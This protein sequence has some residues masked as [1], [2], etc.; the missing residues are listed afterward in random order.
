MVNTRGGLDLEIDVGDRNTPILTSK[1]KVR[2]QRETQVR[3]VSVR[4]VGRTGDGEGIPRRES[5]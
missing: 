5:R 2:R 1:C 3:E 4:A